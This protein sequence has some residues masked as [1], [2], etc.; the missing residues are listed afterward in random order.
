MRVYRS[1]QGE[2]KV[3]VLDEIGYRN[4]L[5]KEWKSTEIKGAE[6]NEVTTYLRGE[7]GANDMKSDMPVRFETY[8]YVNQV[9]TPADQI[10]MIIAR[11]VSDTSLAIGFAFLLIALFSTE[12]TKLG[13]IS[14]LVICAAQI[15]V[16]LGGHTVIPADHVSTE[17]AYSERIM[18][19]IQENQTQRRMNEE[20]RMAPPNQ[21]T[22]MIP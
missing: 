15:G 11:V 10:P 1:H 2:W 22:K 19:S 13:F 6:T 16:M 17:D 21:R 5:F 7:L 12:F 9:L 8:R 3:N 18:R 20:Q 4:D 14:I